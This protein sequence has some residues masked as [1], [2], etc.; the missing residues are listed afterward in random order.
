MKPTMNGATIIWCV[1]PQNLSVGDIVLY[2]RRGQMGGLCHRIIGIDADENYLIKG[3]NAPEIDVVP[4]SKIQYKVDSFR[5][6]F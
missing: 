2:S 3:D 5:N 4:L 1:K 6:I